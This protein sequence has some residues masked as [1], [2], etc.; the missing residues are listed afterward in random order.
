MGRKTERTAG[1]SCRWK[2]AIT[3]SVSIASNELGENEI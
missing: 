2:N 1:C 3:P